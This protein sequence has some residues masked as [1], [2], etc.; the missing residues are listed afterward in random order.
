M[1]K[2]VGRL[3][4][5]IL[6]LACSLAGADLLPGRFLPLRAPSA[7]FRRDRDRRLLQHL[8]GR[9]RVPL[10]RHERRARPLRRLPVQALPSSRGAGPPRANERD[11]SRD[12]LSVRRHLGRDDRTGPLK[13]SRGDRG[14]HRV[15]PHSR[16]PRRPVRR[17]RHGRPGGPAG[18]PLDRDPLARPH[19]VRSG[20][21]LV[22]RGSPLG[23]GADVV[24]DVLADR[25]GA[26]WVGTL[27]AGLFRIDPVTGETLHFESRAGDPRSLGS[28][29]V[30]TLFED[31]EGTLWI[32]T[33]NGGLGRYDPD[34]DGLRP[35]LRGRGPAA[36]SRRPDDI[37]HSRGSAGRLWL[38]TVA[39]GL[40][41][42]DRATGRVGPVPAR[43]PGPRIP[44][45]RQRHLD[46]AGR[47]GSHLG[48]HGPG[49]PEQVPGRPRPSSSTTSG[50]RRIA[51]ASAH[52]DVRA[53]W[54]D[55][56]GRS[57]WERRRAARS[58]ST[59]GPA[60]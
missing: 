35:L 50:T 1:F 48:R 18:A 60:R 43:S 7:R 12:D 20:D 4:P 31:R 11:L 55:G 26:I 23:P 17:H 15:R 33:K 14:V 45:R 53:L 59:A 51:E 25:N 39:D 2:R 29:C 8:P 32:G 21:G 9:G 40:R 10:A 22:L 56:R 16:G 46:H 54:A 44:G 58:G 27:D 42:F 3:L 38:G 13:F 28:N 49:R 24:G 57:G 41:I 52:N 37:G 6:V 5:G 19:P 34:R 47:V 36:R 30:W